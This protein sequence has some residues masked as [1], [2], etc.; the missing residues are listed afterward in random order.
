MNDATERV[1]SR[2]ASL[3]LCAA[4]RASKIPE[5]STLHLGSFPR[6]RRA[7]VLLLLVELFSDS[8]GLPAGLLVVVPAAAESCAM[9]SPSPFEGC[10]AKKSWISVISTKITNN[11]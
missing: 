6:L 1:D 4:R 7:L 11:Y 5:K 2:I 9:I 8:G 3:E 10:P